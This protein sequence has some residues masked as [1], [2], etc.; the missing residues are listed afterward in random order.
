[1]LEY[2]RFRTALATA[3]FGDMSETARQALR[4]DKIHILRQQGR[5]ERMDARAQQSEIDELVRQEI[6]LKEAPPFEKWLLRKRAAQA[7]LP[8]TEPSPQAV[9]H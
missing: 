4:A 7:V 3:V 1:V 9:A 8:F 2:E 5:W 6:A